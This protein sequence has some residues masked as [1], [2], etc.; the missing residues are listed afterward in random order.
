M[1]SDWAGLPGHGGLIEAITDTDWSVAPVDESTSDHTSVDEALAAGART[2]NSSFALPYYKHAPISPEIA[3]ADARRDGTVH[4][5]SSSQHAQGL[6]VKIATMLETDPADVTVHFAD[7]AGGFGRTNKGDAGSEAEAVLLSRACGRPVRLQ[8]MREEDFAWSAQQSAYFGDVSVALDEDGRMQAIKIEHFHP[9]RYNDPLLGAVLAGL[10]S[11]PRVPPFA[12]PPP[13]CPSDRVPGVGYVNLRQVDWR[14]DGVPKVLDVAYGAEAIGQSP[15]AVNLG[16]RHRSMRSPMHLQQNFAVEC[17]V[18]EAAAAA[19]A[20]PIQYRLDHTTDP[21][22]IG[23]LETARKLS[24]WEARPSPAARAVGDVAY[25]RG[26]AVALRNGSY[27]AAVTEISID[28]TSG[29]VTVDRY[30]LAADVGMIVNP[31]QL[32]LNLEG[33]TVMGISQALR[34]ELQFNTS[35]ITSTDFKSYP[36]LTM[37]EIPEI[38]IE[39]I[40]NPD[41]KVGQGSEPANMLPPVALAAAFFDATGSPIRKLPLRPKYVLAELRDG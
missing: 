26:A 24:G 21:R 36:I 38:E 1:W 2:L 30:W 32:E 18:N 27:L 14:Y 29:L 7:G 40:N 37:A 20:D 4:V 23:V 10:P 33:G 25:G 3:V 8:W 17:M 11:Q 22:L 39:L 31:R 35:S 15:S 5:W 41:A 9:G 6:K 13:N 12:T 34:E 19:G 28:V 16:L